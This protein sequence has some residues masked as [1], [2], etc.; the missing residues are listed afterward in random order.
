MNEWE[1]LKCREIWYNNERLSKCPKCGCDFDIKGR[2][3]EE[4]GVY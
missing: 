3:L 1:C 2:L 4:R